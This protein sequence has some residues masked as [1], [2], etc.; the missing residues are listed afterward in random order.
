MALLTILALLT[1]CGSSSEEPSA[2][3][4]AD[5][6][7]A[8]EATAESTTPTTTIDISLAL[9]G[10]TEAPAGSDSTTPEI[11]ALIL[12]KFGL[13][14]TPWVMTEDDWETKLTA[15]AAADALPDF[16][17]I[18][19]EEGKLEMLTWIDSGVIRDIPSQCYTQYTNLTRVMSYASTFAAQDGKMYVIPRTSA[20]DTV[21]RGSSTALYFRKDWAT[22]LGYEV[23]D[24][25]T[26]SNFISLMYD[27]TRKDPNNNNIV[28]TRGITLADGGEEQLL[29]TFLSCFGV[30]DWVL[31][32]GQWVPGLISNRAKE[33]VTWINQ[34]YR[35]GIIDPEYDQMTQQDA[36]N[37]FA[38][39]QAGMLVADATRHGAMTLRTEYWS[40]YNPDTDISQYVAVYPLPTDPYGVCYDQEDLFTSGT[41]VSAKVDDA[42]LTQSLAL[43]EWMYTQEGLTALTY[44]AA[45]TDY[46]VIADGTVQSAYTDASGQTVSYGA[47]ND[48]MPMLKNLS[49]WNE[50]GLSA[51]EPATTFD[52][53]CQQR[54]E[55]LWWINRWHTPL[56]T[57]YMLT[58]ELA[59]F[60]LSPVMD[61]WL[62][63]LMMTSDLDTTWAS[64]VQACMDD[65][66]TQAT[67]DEVNA[68]A[69][70]HG[71]NTEE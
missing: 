59:A 18:N 15:A 1:G 25:V 71:I 43:F 13:N 40:V 28:D 55:S 52:T 19:L 41:L 6:T 66:N 3:A 2:S 49:T 23:G 35:D 12:D 32:D 4:Q 16:F 31:E 57:Q 36:N 21:E 9:W 62:Q 8:P 22:A 70:R 56:F 65:L 34:L 48:Q 67:I 50:D 7:Q 47:R 38:S 37:K 14:I 60:D 42:A 64:Y 11:L 17:S 5:Q 26:W 51:L 68:Y 27:Y 20:S 58:P 24:T 63:D 44:G 54:L 45:D 61:T 30:R 69:T 33:A 46:T 53:E 10:N 29:N 39:G